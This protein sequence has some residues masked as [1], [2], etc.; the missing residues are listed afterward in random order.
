MDWVWFSCM[1]VVVVNVFLEGK[2]G[3]M[4]GEINGEIV[5]IFFEQAIKYYNEIN[6]MFFEM[7]DILF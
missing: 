4:I 5:Y 1:G 3:V 2:L 7:V 6:L